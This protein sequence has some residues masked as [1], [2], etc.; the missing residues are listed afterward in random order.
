[1]TTAARRRSSAPTPRL[2]EEV[3]AFAVGTSCDRLP[4]EVVRKA[5]LCIVDTLS[6]CLTVSEGCAA[7]KA[8]APGREGP[9]SVFGTSR[10]AAAE[11][12]AFVNA[13]TAAATIRTDTHPPSA[14]HP[15][16]VVIPAV[17]ALGEE[18]RIDGRAA[19]AGIVAGYEF[20]IRL[21]LAVVT[22]ELAAVFRPTGLIGP[23]GA[24]LG[25]SRALRLDASATARAVALASHQSAGFNE[26]V[27][28]GT[29][30]HIYHGG[31]AAQ[32]AI[33]AIRLAMA[34]AEAAPSILEGRSGLLAGFRALERA[35]AVTRE[36][37][38]RFLI[39][40]VVHKP[41][42]ACIFVQAPAQAATTLLA[43]RSVDPDAIEAI[44]IRTSHQAI[45]FPGCDNPGP[46]ADRT[47]AEQSLQ[48]GVAAVF[49]AGGVQEALWSQPR[50]PAVNRLASRCRLAPI[51][52]E[53]L[54]G[55]PVQLTVRLRDGGSLE[56][57]VPDFRSMDE[58][59]VVERFLATAVPV[60]G[61][62]RAE[63]AA[64]RV[65]AFETELDVNAVTAL[66]TPSDATRAS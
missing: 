50:H 6:A 17:L 45:A 47:S 46:F 56:A 43:A 8:L 52:N 31:F 44:E 5:K 4:A 66:L 20:M 11:S 16:M 53:G 21:G 36:L 7:L 2:V 38:R 62:A 49:A 29:N 55:Q 32:N 39:L 64:D 57:A 19:L 58:D 22:P 9:G 48:F 23:A 65:L 25:A 54:G 63:E 41:V 35:A 33:T 34:G 28:A 3:A 24:A 30:E 14:S 10:R 18:R 15:G 51:E 26:W 42:P 1:M 12:A 60:L 61:A 27:H 13:V 37:G 59:A 40:D